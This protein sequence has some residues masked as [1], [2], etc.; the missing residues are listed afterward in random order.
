MGSVSHQQINPVLLDQLRPVVRRERWRLMVSFLGITWIIVAIG[1]MIVYALNRSAE[2]SLDPYFP[3]A[4]MWVAAVVGI[5]TI[6]AIVFS[7][8]CMPNAEKMAHRIEEGFPEL[9][10]VLLT[11]IEQKPDQNE[12]LSF[13]QH[14]VI[15]KAV[16]H[17]SREKWASVVPTWKLLSSSLGALVGLVG[18]AFACLLLMMLP[19]PEFDPSIHLFGDIEKPL[20]LDFSCKVQPGNAEIERG[21][22]LL[23]LAEFEE[24][25]PPEAELRYTDESGE[26]RI[27]SM[28]KSLDD[29]VFAS[30]IMR[31]DQPLS[32]RVEFADETSEEFTVTVFEY[33][34]L[35]RTDV[36]LSYPKY[37]NL[38]AKTLQDTRRFS[39]VV[40]TEAKLQF[41]LNK[42]V[43][44]A[45]LRPESKDLEI[46][47]LSQNENNPLLWETDLVVE[48]SGKYRL[49]LKDDRQ[50]ENK[51]PPRLTI[52]ALTNQPPELKLLDPA[53]DIAVSAIEEISLS[54]SVRDDF[55]VAR[56]GLTWS[57]GGGDI[58]E[59]ELATSQSGRKKH[60]VDHLLELESLEA[61]PDQL[62]SW[63][64]WAEDI[65]PDG[66]ARRTES[67]MFFAE[68]RRFEEMFFEAQGGQN[69]QQQQQQQQGQQGP[70]AEQAMELAELQKEIINATWR[71]IRREKGPELTV[72]FDDDVKL[73]VESQ[74]SAITQVD[75]L[76]ENLNDDLAKTLVDE[77]KSI[78]NDAVD[79][80]DS[81]RTEPSAKPL[82]KAI[83]SQQLAWQTL[84]RMRAREIQ[85]QQSQQQQR[86]Q[87]QSS[88]SS[89]QRQLQQ[90]ELTEREDRYE[91]ERQAQE[92]SEQAQQQRKN[93]QIL[94]RL[95]ELAQRQNDL[96]KR[97][98]EL[99]S[100]LEEAETEEEKEELEKQLKRL[101]EE[102]QQVL[103]DTD[104]LQERM[105]ESDSQQTEQMEQLQQA[106]ENVQRSSEA[107][108]QGDLSKA[109]N[110][111]TRAERELE[112]LRDEFQKQTAG[113]FN[114][115]MRQMR[116]E[117]QDLQ[118]EQEELSDRLKNQDEDDAET[119]RLD[120]TDKRKELMEGFRKGQQQVEELREKIKETIEE[121]D[122]LEPLLADE[123]YDTYRE[124]EKSRP[125]RALQY[126]ADAIER[127]FDEDA[128]RI[129]EAAMGGIEELREGI[130]KAAERV[131]GDETEALKA[132][133]DTI[134]NL[135]RELE[136]E[137][138]RNNPDV[139]ESEQRNGQPAGETRE[140]NSSER[141]PGQRDSG[142]P[143]Q[144]AEGQRG[145]QRGQNEPGENEENSD[146][147][148]DGSGQG[149]REN[150]E[151]SNN[152]E[153]P[154]SGGG[155]QDGQAEERNDGEQE[156]Q[157]RR[158]SRLDDEPTETGRRG[159]IATPTNRG[160][161]A[162]ITGEDFRDWS[163]RLRDVEEMI[164]DP[165]LRADAARI[166]DKA[167]AIR[168]DL[169]RHSP[170]PD[171]DKIKM[172]LAEPLA[173]LRS[174]VTQEILRRDPKNALVPLNQEPVP[175]R[176]ENAVRK[177]YETLGTGQ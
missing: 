78:M 111:G 72:A 123:L 109:A 6:A 93:R 54:A 91:Q 34:R 148:R 66:Q 12:G 40:G 141:Q 99:Q 15:Q 58:Q 169:K 11:A 71:V 64:F 100:A 30:R 144:E 70:S 73:L 92:E 20:K 79:K 60:I 168:K 171:W 80:L 152:Q 132:A 97:V 101:E 68:V 162:P 175:T 146:S 140:R 161:F 165:D 33:P 19:T 32:Y 90:M 137:L 143:N 85:V 26:D 131:L 105:E 25:S 150:G 156:S 67:D 153:S 170:E 10:S 77:L 157:R 49:H 134:K 129:H 126:S 177:Y 4:W 115:Q 23:V 106:R 53:R 63:H 114:E 56:T 94:S 176:Y 155:Q 167:R 82:T 103:R 130:D 69:Q 88:Q 142:E 136:D 127:G 138:Q 57:V 5:G 112:E 151:N 87:S 163:D 145:R 104:E 50:R 173:E 147:P 159:G 8:L 86:S 102:Q 96:N 35:V 21:T 22:N 52:K 75:E 116:N 39:A 1:G 128:E 113:Q 47:R 124:T 107:L 65:G 120:G 29:P 42:E 46:L 13:F 164:P 76:A 48:Q 84:L 17:S 14:D 166:R 18:V 7:L 83:S 59:L 28:T 172:E 119:N 62:I 24:D 2:S 45:T 108:Q 3:S 41:N 110:E 139:E 9:D 121:A 135:S 174:R 98:K 38:P 31:V 133:R 44:S 95:K 149:E 81:A 158:R 117:V 43:V 36:V 61:E 27:V 125:D 89:R 55:C 16:R 37:T 118:S 122:E 154:R 74:R 51:S 160:N